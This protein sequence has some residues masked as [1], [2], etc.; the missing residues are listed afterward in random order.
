MI[1]SQRPSLQATQLPHSFV[2]AVPLPQTIVRFKPSPAVDASV[3]TDNSVVLNFNGK[4][5]R[6]RLINNKI[7]LSTIKD[8]FNLRSVQLNGL[9]EPVDQLGFTVA[10]FSP[11]QVVS[12]SG[13]PTTEMEKLQAEI[14]ALRAELQS[15]QAV[16]NDLHNVASMTASF[17]SM[18]GSSDDMMRRLMAPGASPD[19]VTVI[20]RLLAEI[21]MRSR[22]RPDFTKT[23]QDGYTFDTFWEGRMIAKDIINADKEARAARGR[24][25][26]GDASADEALASFQE[27]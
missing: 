1:L 16:R 6:I 22:D 11:G 10:E 12:V 23:S 4:E 24:H 9:T 17:S 7:Q 14:G 21:I 25:D 27:T 26:E 5:E 13:S 19:D 20:K 2:K 15:L 18:A 8:A 3:D